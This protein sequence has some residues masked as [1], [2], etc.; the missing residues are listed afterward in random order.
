MSALV[1]ERL[2]SA[3]EF[4]EWE[5]EQTLRH[6]LINSRVVEMTGASRSHNRINFN[7]AFALENRLAGKGCEVFGIDMGVLV[8]REANFTYPDVIVVCGEPRFRSDSPQDTLENP[9]LLFEI[10]SPSTESIDRNQKLRQYLQ[11]D[12]LKGYFLVA[13]DK[14]L[15]EAYMRSGDDWLYR[16]CAGLESGLVI[17]A[18]DCE[19]PLSEV[20]RQV[21]FADA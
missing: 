14:P 15:I 9:T 6:E 13:Q 1:A 12:S 2:W 3:E 5:S 16:E 20:Y 11:L 19:I 4:L 18:L 7:F 17:A 21:R 10:L 8:D